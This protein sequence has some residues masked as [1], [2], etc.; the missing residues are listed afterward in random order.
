MTSTIDLD[1]TISIISALIP[2]I[3]VVMVL[4]LIIGMLGGITKDF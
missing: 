2:L 1:S 4:K 3:V